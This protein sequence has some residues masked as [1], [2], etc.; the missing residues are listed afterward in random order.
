MF[1]FH[2][3]MFFFHSHRL[4]SAHTDGTALA[5]AALID[6]CIDRLHRA[7]TDGSAHVLKFNVRFGSTLPYDATQNRSRAMFLASL[8]PIAK[9]PHRWHCDDALSSRPRGSDRRWDDSK[10]VL[11]FRPHNC[12]DNLIGSHHHGATRRRVPPVA[13]WS[14]L[15]HHTDNLELIIVE[16]GR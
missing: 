11:V 7:H 10:A 8:T 15:T 5:D 14:H 13:P 9:C 1:F 16:L 4:Q 3:L 12:P 6:C 2:S